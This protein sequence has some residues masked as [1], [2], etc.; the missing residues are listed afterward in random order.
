MTKPS[1]KLVGHTAISIGAGVGAFCAK[2]A[3]ITAN[4]WMQAG[5]ISVG[6]ALAAAGGF[7]AKRATP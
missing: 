5:F 3:T 1:Q 2:G 4:P 7:T 6:V